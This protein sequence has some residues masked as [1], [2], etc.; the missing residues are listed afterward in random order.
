[1]EICFFTL[2][3][4]TKIFYYIIINIYLNKITLFKDFP[5]EYDKTNI[6]KD[7]ILKIRTSNNETE[8]KRPFL[9]KK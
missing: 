9:L 6:S 8:E 1:M 4:T 5:G 7:S 2:L 3:N